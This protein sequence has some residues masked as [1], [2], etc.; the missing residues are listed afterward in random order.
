MTETKIIKQTKNNKLKQ[1]LTNQ[2]LLKITGVLTSNL[3]TRESSDIPYMAFFRMEEGRDK[4]GYYCPSHRMEH[5]LAE[6]IKQKC[7]ECEI[8]VVFRIGGPPECKPMIKKG[9][10]VILE[11]EFANS[12][13][14]SR[15]SFTCYSYQIL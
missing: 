5:K 4:E 3:R 13:K 11:G 6:C 9:D 15:P 7:K 14:S 2:E 1:P 10:R 12:S 8:P